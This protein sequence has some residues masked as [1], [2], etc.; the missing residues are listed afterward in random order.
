MEVINILSDPIQFPSI[1]DFTFLLFGN[2][3]EI[4]IR[5]RLF[6]TEAVKYSKHDVAGANEPKL[7]ARFKWYHRKFQ[8]PLLEEYY[9]LDFD[10]ET[11]VLL[12]VSEET[13]KE[14]DRVAIFTNE[15][16]KF[17]LSFRKN[18]HFSD[19]LAFLTLDE[20]K[21]RISKEMSYNNKQ[22]LF[23]HPEIIC[24]EV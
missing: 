19:R 3:G 16:K 8:I 6:D 24:K 18:E 9:Q 20:V 7:L 23:V 12:K 17:W 13:D 11:V 1:Y 22:V 10:Q 15:G 4:R 5:V 2:N 21:R 14:H